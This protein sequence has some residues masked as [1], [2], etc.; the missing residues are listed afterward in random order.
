MGDYQKDL[1]LMRWAHPRLLLSDELEKALVDAW[2]QAAPG[3][4]QHRVLD[5]GCGFQ[6]GLNSV[7][8]IGSGLR[9]PR[10]EYSAHDRY[11]WPRNA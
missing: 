11:S 6:N 2:L 7:P 8:R 1:A 4:D 3:N 9:L 5:A 10:F